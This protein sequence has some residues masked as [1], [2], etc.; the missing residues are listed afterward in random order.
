VKWAITIAGLI[1]TVA[2]AYALLGAR[3]MYPRW[4]R[5]ALGLTGI[6]LAGTLWAI[7]PNISGTDPDGSS[8]ADQWP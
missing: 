6:L 2:A 4:K 8:L 7:H 3:F 1:G 5:W